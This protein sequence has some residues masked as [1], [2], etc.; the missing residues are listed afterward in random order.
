MAHHPQNS[1]QRPGGDRLGERH[2]TEHLG[3]ANRQVGGDART[4]VTQ[5]ARNLLTDLGD[6]AEQFRFLITLAGRH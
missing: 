4:S 5:Q 2:G 6:R 1:P 3:M